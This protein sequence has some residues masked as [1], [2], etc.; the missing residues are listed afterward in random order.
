MMPTTTR[1]GA[2]ACDGTIPMIGARMMLNRNISAVTTEVR[3]VR[4]PAPIPAALST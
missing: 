1:A 3:P 4:P 2:V